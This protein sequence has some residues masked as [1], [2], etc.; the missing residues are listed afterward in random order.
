MASY[1]ELLAEFGGNDEEVSLESQAPVSSADWDSVITETAQNYPNIPEQLVRSLI[2]RESSGDPY[3]EIDTGTKWG[4]ARG[5]GQFID[6]TAK[7]YIPDWKDPSDSYDPVKNIKGIYA[8]L[9]DL[10]KKTGSLEKALIKYHG[11]STDILGTKSEDYAKQI[12]SKVKDDTSF[13]P[14]SSSY[15]DLL[16]EFGGVT[17][18]VTEQPTEQVVSRGDVGSQ[19]FFEKILTGAKVGAKRAASDIATAIGTNIEGSVSPFA[20]A[21]FHKDIMNRGKEIEKFFTD[22]IDN[23]M[24]QE[25]I[26]WYY[27]N[28]SKDDIDAYDYYQ[29]QKVREEGAKKEASGYYKYAENIDKTISDTDKTIVDEATQRINSVKNVTDRLKRGDIIGLASDIVVSGAG[30]ASNMLLSLMP[31]GNVAREQGSLASE[32]RKEGIDDPQLIQKYSVINA[33][34]SGAVEQFT[35]KL[36]LEPITKAIKSAG[37]N[38]QLTKQVSKKLTVKLLTKEIA[39]FLGGAASEGLEEVIQ[40]DIAN[41]TKIAALI[42]YTESLTSSKDKEKAQLIINKTVDLAKRSWGDRA[43]EFIGG[44]LTGIGMSGPTKIGGKAV[45]TL[46]EKK[47]RSDN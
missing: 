34:P 44:W 37:A 41:A 19:N 45:K 8:Y 17:E 15:E 6:E 30:Q 29:K 20:D 32:L 7:R 11:G 46:T 10:V 16:A 35:D 42:E 21:K 27:N 31:L 26:E 22:A 38:K 18:Q 9:D 36:L 24:H 1:E 47:V 33:I 14:K 2:Q 40:G 13:K 12:L 5:L 3:A 28:L 43:D 39:K 23:K 25:D 4:K